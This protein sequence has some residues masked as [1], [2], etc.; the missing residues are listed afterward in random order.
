MHTMS[1]M[2]PRTTL[3]VPSRVE[4]TITSS[5]S[6]P[7]QM[8]VS[9]GNK[10]HKTIASEACITPTD[11]NDT[12][13]WKLNES[14]LHHNR[15]WLGCLA[16][17]QLCLCAH[18][19]VDSPLIIRYEVWRVFYQRRAVDNLWHTTTSNRLILTCHTRKV[20]SCQL[21][22]LWV[23]VIKLGVKQS[24]ARFIAYRVNPVCTL[25]KI[26]AMLQVPH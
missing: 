6:T 26:P 17:S 13:A 20:Y 11:S 16:C 7:I 14:R 9:E 8:E 18:L 1:W 5:N 4:H 23:V 24:R 2:G 12:I 25:Y 21:A 10:A 15:F 19:K 22:R 3:E